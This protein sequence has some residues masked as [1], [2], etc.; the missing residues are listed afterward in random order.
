VAPGVGL[1]CAAADASPQG[2]L[3][4]LTGEDR[5]GGTVPSP[6]FRDG[7][8]NQRVLDAIERS[9]EARRWVRVKGVA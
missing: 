1:L 9:S 2:H 6:S 4:A 8:I 3:R 5:G 7:V